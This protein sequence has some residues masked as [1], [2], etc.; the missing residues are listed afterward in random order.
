MRQRAVPATL[1]LGAL[2]I[3]AGGSAVAQDPRSPQRFLPQ[4]NI[5]STGW[6]WC[7]LPG[8]T[9]IPTEYPCAC[10]D[11]RSGRPLPGVTRAFNYTAFPWPVSPYLNPHWVPP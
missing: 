5:C 1:L 7:P 10:Y 6:G 11:P 3:A 9:V 8:G 2:L 4:A